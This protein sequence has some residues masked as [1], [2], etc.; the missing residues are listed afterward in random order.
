MY[1]I[2]PF[3]LSLL[4][5]I[6]T[7]IVIFW[8][9]VWLVEES[10]LILE[11]KQT[12]TIL[13]RDIHKYINTQTYIYT[14]HLSVFCFFPIYFVSDILPIKKR[15]E[16][17]IKEI[18]CWIREY[19]FL[20]SLLFCSSPSLSVRTFYT[21][22][23]RFNALN[24]FLRESLSDPQC[25]TISLI[26]LSLARL[27][28][29]FSHTFVYNWTKILPEK[30]TLTSSF[31]ILIVL[32]LLRFQFFMCIFNLFWLQALFSLLF[33]SFVLDVPISLKHRLE[34]KSINKTIFFY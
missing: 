22:F 11:K 18:H 20:M 12:R 1:I 15:T 19:F 32:L 23:H 28:D 6:I 17:L 4:L 30:L 2:N 5:L 13:V 16:R 7:M 26:P 34:S 25:R 21:T 29:P 27:F 33:L 8:N 14:N 9:F 3:L 24:R 10:L 31:W